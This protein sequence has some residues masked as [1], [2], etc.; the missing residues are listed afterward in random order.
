MRRILMVACLANL[1]FAARPVIFDTDMGND[2]DDALALAMLHALSDRGECQLIGVTLTNGHPAAVPYIRM[3]NRFY[4]RGD[5]P[6]GAAIK[7]LKDGAQDGYMTA[8]LRGA[9][10]Q[11]AGPAEPAPALLGRLLANAREKAIPERGMA[12]LNR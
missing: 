2:I 9:P 5:L 7:Q 4:G 10:A 3:V 11:N 6:V 12:F 1:C 8:A